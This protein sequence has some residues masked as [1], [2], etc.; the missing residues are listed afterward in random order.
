MFIDFRVP[1]VVPAQTTIAVVREP[2]EDELIARLPGNDQEVLKSLR[3]AL[4]GHGGIAAR[5]RFGQMFEKADRPPVPGQRK[6]TRLEKAQQRMA[7]AKNLEKS[8][9]TK[10]AEQ[11][12]EQHP[13]LDDLDD[14]VI[15]HF[16]VGVRLCNDRW[17]DWLPDGWMPGSRKFTNGKTGI[18]FVAP[19]ARRAECA[20]SFC[21]YQKY[22]V[23]R[24]ARKLKAHP[25][26][27]KQAAMLKQRGK[28]ISTAEHHPRYLPD[29]TSLNVMFGACNTRK[30]V[31]GPRMVMTA[32]GPMRGHVFQL[33]HVENSSS[34]SSRADHAM[35]KQWVCAVCKLTHTKSDHVRASLERPCFP[36]IAGN[37]QGRQRHKTR[38]K[39]V[40]QRRS[41]LPPKRLTCAGEG[42]GSRTKR[43]RTESAWGATGRPPE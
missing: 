27:I 8:L 13:V 26:A 16:P 36:S 19:W 12:L 15:K 35:K 39:L 31:K 10:A 4:A 17:Y 32:S 33:E 42:T 11:P 41:M 34:S 40:A 37:V 9:L 43:P 20:M 5:S 6:P 21:L 23:L 7:W 38:V 24:M 3:A 29:G 18:V 14:S 1:Q 22:K 2:T 28:L 25:D 30:R